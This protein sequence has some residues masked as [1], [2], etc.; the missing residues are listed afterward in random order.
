MICLDILRIFACL[1]VV[2]VHAS[3]AFN[4]QGRIGEFMAAGSSGLGVFYILSG[5]LIFISLDR[6]QGRLSKWY[7]KRMV[8][9]L[10]MYYFM[11]ILYMVVYGLILHDIPADPNKIKWLSYFLCI[12][13]V[14]KRQVD[15]WFNIGALSSMSVF[16]WFY[17]LAPILKR[18]V[19]NWNR[20]LVFMALSY[21]LL[22]ILQHTEYLYMF[23]TY[24]Y[25]AIGIM[26]YYAMK[27]H[28]E[29]PTTILALCIEVF[30]ML[31]DG[32]GG[33]MYG[34]IIGLIILY[35]NDVQINNDKIVS[36]IRFL[37]KRTFAV[38]FAHTAVMQLMTVLG[39][40]RS[41]KGVAMA[42]VYTVAG[43]VIL[44]EVVEKNVVKLYNRS[45]MKQ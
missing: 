44:Y 13:S 24:Y 15:F 8:R 29:K 26:I 2:A 12:N 6:L 32:Q 30:L 23:R 16:M 35:T 45:G 34:L 31:A 37:S 11:V 36:I 5:F 22:R 19:S 40:D 7:A 3:I 27:E 10:P 14:L 39:I 43:V 21:V 42:V 1:S 20:S 18:V 28:K 25:F 9:I 41:V 4:I 33:L 17:I 38:Y